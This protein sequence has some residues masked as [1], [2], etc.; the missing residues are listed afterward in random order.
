[1]VIFFLLLPPL[2]HPVIRSLKSSPK[3][4]SPAIPPV[5]PPL[6][7]QPNTPLS[8]ASGITLCEKCPITQKTPTT[9]FFGSQKQRKY[10]WIHVALTTNIPVEVLHDDPYFV[11]NLRRFDRIAAFP[12]PFE[13]SGGK[14]QT[15]KAM[16]LKLLLR[17]FVLNSVLTNPGNHDRL[18]RFFHI[19]QSNIFLDFDFCYLSRIRANPISLWAKKNWF[20]K[21]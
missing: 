16:F 13:E 4:I 8:C 7:P 20:D 15:L 9:C 1:M 14:I 10:T 17:T 2:S 3:F 21:K 19:K 11:G 6:T 18:Y 5:T 12:L